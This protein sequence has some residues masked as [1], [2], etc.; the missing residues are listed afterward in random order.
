MTQVRERKVEW[1]SVLFKGKWSEQKLM[2]LTVLR[3]YHT[4]RSLL[5]H[6]TLSVY[7]LQERLSYAKLD[8][9]RIQTAREQRVAFPSKIVTIM[10]LDNHTVKFKVQRRKKMVAEENGFIFLLN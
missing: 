9:G 7:I 8:W 1:N 6:F 10:C 3:Q 5:S 4:C 2:G